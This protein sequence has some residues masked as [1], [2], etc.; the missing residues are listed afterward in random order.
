MLN[1]ATS[2]KK[3]GYA[4][5][6]NAFSGNDVANIRSR[7]DQIFLE[8]GEPKFLIASD[9]INEEIIVGAIFN[10]G[11]TNFLKEILGD[12]FVNYSDYMIHKN[13][14][15]ID[16]DGW[17]LDCG[18][19]GFTDYLLSPDYTYGKCGIYLQSNSVEYGGGVD[20]VER[21]HLYPTRFFP[22]FFLKMIDKILLSQKATR[23][24]IFRH[25]LKKMVNMFRQRVNYKSIALQA[26]DFLF[27]DARLPHRSTLPSKKMNLKAGR[28]RNTLDLPRESSKYV[29]YWN[30]GKSNEFKDFP[31][32]H[33]LRRSE[34]ETSRAGGEVFFSDYSSLKYPDDYPESFVRIAEERSVTVLTP[35]DLSTR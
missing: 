12:R 3:K 23:P 28:H 33:S 14:Y 4:L 21:G 8:K 11:V 15:I 25:Y 22:R 1:P 32:M 19:E 17:H 9:I 5:L 26:G 2:F 24:M 34:V 16:G 30:S 27:F 6:K 20:V 35:V 31:L 18:S 10:E 13:Y 7:L 29:I